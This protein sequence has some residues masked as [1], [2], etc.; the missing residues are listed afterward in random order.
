MKT[1]F[2]VTRNVEEGFSMVM[3]LKDRNKGIPGLALAFGDPGLGKTRWGIYLADK[4]GAIFVRALAA[5]TLRSFLEDLVFELGLEPMF[6][7][8]DLYRQARKA[9]S[10]DPR[11]V[12]IDEIDRLIV[13]WQ[14]I[15]M[16]R[17]LSDETDVPILLIGMDTAER[18]LSRFRHLYYRMKSHV[19]RFTPLS[20]S[21]VRQFVDK[22]SEINLDD[23]AISQIHK[24]TGGRIGDII[25]E[26]HRVER[27]ALANNYKTIQAKHLTR[28]AA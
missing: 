27:I 16:L 18:K 4:L 14:A 23:S 21:D 26:L 12:I 3:S 11:L 19:V 10:E 9:L 13:N 1:N 2:V 17:D 5:S 25:S 24:T 15:E 6:R 28:R 8:A 7:S 22:I 20:E